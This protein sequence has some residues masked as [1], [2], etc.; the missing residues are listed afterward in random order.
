MSST[1]TIGSLASAAGVPASTLR[2]YERVGLLV[3][4]HRSSGNYRLYDCDDLSRLRFIK[5][6]Q[7]AGFTLDDIRLLLGMEPDTPDV[8]GEVQGLIRQRLAGVEAKLRELR[9]VRRVLRESLDRCE[10]SPGTGRCEV[11]DRLAEVPAQEK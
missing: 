11:I 9:R 7:A 2:Y 10:R 6:A 3:P 1:Y 8:C 5:A 4:G